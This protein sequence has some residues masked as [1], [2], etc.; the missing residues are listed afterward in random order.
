MGLNRLKGLENGS[1]LRL[2][3]HSRLG[4]ISTLVLVLILV[5]VPVSVLVIPLALTWTLIVPLPLPLIEPLALALAI[6]TWT[7]P[8]LLFRPI[9]LPGRARLGTG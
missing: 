1:S 2:L 7:F 4:T 5:S 6:T 8:T 9:P 3:L